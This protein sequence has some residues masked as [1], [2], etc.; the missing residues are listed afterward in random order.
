MHSSH[1]ALLFQIFFFGKHDLS[2]VGVLQSAILI[3]LFRNEGLLGKQFWKCG[4]FFFVGAELIFSLEFRGF[5]LLSAV[6]FLIIIFVWL[7][8]AVESRTPDL[9][10]CPPTPLQGP[11][12]LFRPLS[13]RNGAINKAP[14]ET[15][16][17]YVG[18]K[19]LSQQEISYIICL[20]DLPFIEKSMAWSPIW[21]G[22]I[23]AVALG[24]T[25]F[26][27]ESLNETNKVFKYILKFII[28]E[29]IESSWN[30]LM[31]INFK[32]LQSK[33]FNNKFS[34]YIL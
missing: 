4:F 8:D 3:I 26:S 30:I 32:I 2:V 12:A 17:H 7:C 33:Y 24:D 29:N 11:S 21:R 9:L 20:S 28:M 5:S 23:K 6:A 14:H 27:H 25:V 16:V 1:F 31:D 13:C 18:C 22:S 19:M 15:A 10:S 34:T